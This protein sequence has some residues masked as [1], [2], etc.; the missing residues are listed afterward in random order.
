MHI[1]VITV[2]VVFIRDVLFS[3]FTIQI[4]STLTQD[5]FWALDIVISVLEGQ[6]MKRYLGPIV[7]LKC[8]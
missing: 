8:I 3:K 7:H 2:T 1:V 5:R 6:S 4:F